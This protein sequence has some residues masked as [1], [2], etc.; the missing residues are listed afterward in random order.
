MGS[1]ESLFSLSNKMHVRV[2]KNM[3]DR[4]KG[5]DRQLGHL[6]M[7]LTKEDGRGD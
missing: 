4:I 3:K 5:S 2:E 7:P 1:L 6:P